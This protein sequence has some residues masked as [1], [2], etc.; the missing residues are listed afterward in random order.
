MADDPGQKALSSLQAAGGAAS[1]AASIA[2]TALGALAPLG[3]VAG[4]ISLP[5]VLGNLV[6]QWTQKDTARYPNGWI[7]VPG[8]G[9]SRG[10]GG[11][12]IDP[13]TGRMIQYMGHGQYQ[14]ADDTKNGKLPSPEDLRKWGIEPSGKLAAV[15]GYENVARDIRNDDVNRSFQG[16]PPEGGVAPIPTVAHQ[17]SWLEEWRQP[18]IDQIKAA[19]PNA[20]EGEI[21]RLYTLTDWYQQELAYVAMWGPQGPGG[22]GGPGTSSG[23][24]SDT[25]GNPGGAENY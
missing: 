10:V 4:L 1:L 14:W 2:P 16:A 5:I 6:R 21:W 8:T 18:Y 15:P 19:N 11:F 9:N 3:P 24:N 17:R 7:A 22:E 23:G 13:A 25:P 20:S 12:G